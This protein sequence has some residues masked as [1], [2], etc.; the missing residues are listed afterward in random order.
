MGDEEEEE[1]EKKE[2]EKPAKAVQS[3]SSEQEDSE[4]EEAERERPVDP[5]LAA[6]HSVVS[7][8]SRRT[9]A[10]RGARG[11]KRKKEKRRKEKKERDRRSRRSRERTRSRGRTRAR[12]LRRSPENPV[13]TLPEGEGSEGAAGGKPA[14]SH[15]SLRRNAASRT[16]RCRYR[17]HRKKEA[18][19]IT[20]FDERGVHVFKGRGQHVESFRD[21]RSAFQAGKPVPAEAA[22]E[23]AAGSGASS[24]AAGGAAVEKVVA[25]DDPVAEGKEQA[26]A[27]T[28]SANR[29]RPHAETALDFLSP[30]IESRRALLGALCFS[31]AGRDEAEELLAA[32]SAI[33]SAELV[34]G[35]E[36][37]DWPEIIRLHYSAAELIVSPPE[38]SSDGRG[39][40]ADAAEPGRQPLAGESAQSSAFDG[41]SWHS[42]GLAAGPASDA[43]AEAG[44]QCE[45][46]KP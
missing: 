43:R 22:A 42:A 15:S 27:R 41:S 23:A 14:S 18:D 6:G 33:M 21:L 37:H 40:T 16:Y 7:R 46:R 24:S 29:K 13:P 1:D 36:K 44:E 25:E 20:R 38:R 26:Q 5:R 31:Q 4:E 34:E 39:H 9:G 12:L 35:N 8:C 28:P 17:S 11:L 3:S 2:E 19:V 45:N 30:C 32:M 10:Q